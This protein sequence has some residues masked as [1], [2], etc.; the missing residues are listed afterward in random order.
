MKQLSL[1][2]IISV[3]SLNITA[4]KTFQVSDSLELFENITD[5]SRQIKKQTTESNATFFI[6][7]EKKGVS[8]DISSEHESITTI[9]VLHANR[10]MNSS[11]VNPLDSIY[12]RN[13]NG[14]LQLPVH[15]NNT[16]SLRGLTF[17]DTLFYN[18]LFLPVIFNGKMLPRDLS[19]YNPDKDYETGKLI[20][21]EKTF[22]PKLKHSDFI[23]RVRRNYYVEYP[24][25]I[26]YSILS[27]DSLPNNIDSSDE[28]VRNTFNPFRELLGSETMFSLEAPNVELT[29]IDR[30]YWVRSGEHS[31][32]FAQ[33]YFSENWHKGGTNN[34]N[35]NSIHIVR[36]NYNKDKVKFNNTLEWK[37]S[38]FNAPDDS[39]RKYRIGEDLIRYYGDFGIDAFAKGW[40]Y[41][42]NL[43]AK[44]QLFHS[45]PTNSNQLRSALFSPLYVNAGIGLKFNLEKK[46]DEISGRSI[47]WNL[48]LAPISLNFKYVANDSVDV[49]RYGISENKNYN[50]DIGTTITSII[51]YDITRYITWDSRLTYF[52]G[53][54]KV[55]MEF[56]NSLNM[57]LSNALS[58]RLYINMRFDDGV[59]PHPEFKYWQVNQ[60]LS[61]G[62]NYKW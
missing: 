29:T 23:Q 52:T 58:T 4:S 38:V 12:F 24:D 27:F 53:Y 22:A 19:F 41:S 51:K 56:E 30:K 18:P 42:M 54:D 47:H 49:V 35:I 8:H 2:L 55:E 25:R 59:P 16:E 11:S 60:T 9:N 6:E 44:S 32:Q 14:I 3:F 26:S 15:F 48:A 39:L 28:V 21:Q 17:R 50:L 43:E 40:S 33:N 62:L 31:F 5:I 36:A 10:L 61:F 46:L 37:L 13:E 57:A 1:F 20:P 7:S 34:L 45:Y